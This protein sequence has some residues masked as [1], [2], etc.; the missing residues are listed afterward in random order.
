MTKFSGVNTK[1]KKPRN[2]VSLYVCVLVSWGICNPL[3]IAHHGKDE[4]GLEA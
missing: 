3:R 4:G 2:L 1:G